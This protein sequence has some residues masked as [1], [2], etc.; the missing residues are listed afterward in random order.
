LPLKANF[1]EVRNGWFAEQFEFNARHLTA[2]QNVKAVFFLFFL[3]GRNITSAVT[4]TAQ[5]CLQ[6]K[7]LY[8]MFYF[9]N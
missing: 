7:C 4:G 1:K 3:A 8:S 5:V 9:V 2:H 6:T